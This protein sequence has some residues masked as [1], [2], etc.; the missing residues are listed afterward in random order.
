MFIIIGAQIDIL[1]TCQS[2]APDHSPRNQFKFS[3]LSIK[4][5]RNWSNDWLTA[6]FE[7]NHIIWLITCK[8]QRGADLEKFLANERKLARFRVLN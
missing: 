8:R 1:E 2:H 7:R 4:N 3:L 6:I 5:K